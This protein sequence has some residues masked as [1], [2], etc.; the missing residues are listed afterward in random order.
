MDAHCWYDVEAVSLLP[1]P[2]SFET[3]A[4]DAPSISSFCKV[5][6]TFNI[7]STNK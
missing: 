6:G 3:L 7:N 1:V 4:A 2:V 5:K